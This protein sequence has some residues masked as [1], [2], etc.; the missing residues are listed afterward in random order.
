MIGIS[1]YIDPFDPKDY[2]IYWEIESSV[3]FDNDRYK[4]VVMRSEVEGGVYEEI[5]GK[6]STSS[7]SFFRDKFFNKNT[8]FQSVSYKIKLIDETN[9]SFELFGPRGINLEV[10][11]SDLLI[12]KYERIRFIARGNDLIVFH[13]PRQGQRCS[14]YNEILNSVSDISCPTCFGSGFSKSFSSVFYTKAFMDTEP[15]NL[16]NRA[17]EEQSAQKNFMFPNFP[18]LST[19]DVFVDKINRRYKVLEVYP[20]KPHETIISQRV[21]AIEVNKTDAEMMIPIPSEFMRGFA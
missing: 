13:R 9:N 21:S 11:P 16:F 3:S 15:H 1:F 20:V 19:G 14:C 6:I 8:K 5:S 2:I 17:S 18:I 12:I 4:I 7:I 10:R